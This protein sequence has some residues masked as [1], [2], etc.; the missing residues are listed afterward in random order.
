MAGVD[1]GGLC[2]SSLLF[3]ELDPGFSLLCYCVEFVVCC[4]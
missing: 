1:C 3:G 4:I 2:V